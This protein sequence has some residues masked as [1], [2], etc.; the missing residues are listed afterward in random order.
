[1]NYLITK[2][3]K[4]EIVI[5]EVPTNAK[6]YGNGVIIESETKPTVEQAE[7]ALLAKESGADKTYVELRQ[8]AYRQA[9][10]TP[11]ALAIALTEKLG[12][13]RPAAFEALQA[14]R[15]E[16]KALYPKS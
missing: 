13:N 15:A 14:K 1:M 8:E 7:A 11:A 5:R 16:I 10:I 12:E 4:G 2:N 9:G 3:L 6:T